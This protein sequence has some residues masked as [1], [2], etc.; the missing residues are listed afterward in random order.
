MPLTFSSTPPEGIRWQCW[1]TIRMA[2]AKGPAV[3][4]HSSPSSDGSTT[5]TGWSEAMWDR[6]RWLGWA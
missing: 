1:L 3:Q 4:Q 2:C 5:T 6:V